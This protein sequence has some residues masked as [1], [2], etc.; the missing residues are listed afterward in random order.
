MFQKVFVRASGHLYVLHIL[1]PKE[2]GIINEI[3]K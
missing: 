2:R 1:A 3:Q